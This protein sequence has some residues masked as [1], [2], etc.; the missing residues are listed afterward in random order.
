MSLYKIT[1]FP[2]IPAYTPAIDSDVL[3]ESARIIEN[4][5]S[6]TSPQQ[7]DGDRVAQVRLLNM[8]DRLEQSKATLSPKDAPRG[9]GEEM[10]ASDPTSELARFRAHMAESGVIVSKREGMAFLAG[11]AIGET[12]AFDDVPTVLRAA[13]EIVD[14]S[15]LKGK[16]IGIIDC[17]DASR[18]LCW[19]ADRLKAAK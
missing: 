1:P 11:M 6:C 9:R 18:T 17:N 3:R 5:R 2:E 8:A 4:D 13:A 14:G 19:M 7:R 16:V 15:P 10:S 12:K